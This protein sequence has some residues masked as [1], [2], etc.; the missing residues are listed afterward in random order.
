MEERRE[1]TKSLGLRIQSVFRF[2]GMEK[3]METKVTE[4]QM[5]KEVDLETRLD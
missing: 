5:K 3:Q 1:T 2:H 4:N